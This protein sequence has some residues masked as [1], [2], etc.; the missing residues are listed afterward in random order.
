MVFHSLQLI[1]CIV[2]CQPFHTFCAEVKGQETFTCP[3]CITCLVCGHGD[4]VSHIY[5]HFFVIDHVA[6]T[7]LGVSPLSVQ[8][9]RCVV[10]GEWYH[11]GCVSDHE[12]S[13]VKGAWRC[14]RCTKCLSCK[15]TT[16]GK[17]I[18]TVV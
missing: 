14:V 3:S 18:V 4:N 8:C 13:R 6:S 7:Q 1:R 17:V 10:C 11:R 2:C 15:T 16:P 5:S 9:V 12:S